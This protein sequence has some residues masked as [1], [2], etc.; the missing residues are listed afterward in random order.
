MAGCACGAMATFVGTSVFAS[1]GKTVNQNLQ[2]FVGVVSV[3]AAVLASLQT[4]LRF[5]ERS[6]KHRSVASRY[7]AL[8][9]EIEQTISF[10][11]GGVSPDK[12]DSIRAV[13]DRL[14]EEAPNI[15]TKIWKRRKGVHSETYSAQSNET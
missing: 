14:A 12:M 10:N 13:I 9:R 4:F 1:I 8:R 6:E 3:L 2:I 11:D 15:P 5:S 7:G